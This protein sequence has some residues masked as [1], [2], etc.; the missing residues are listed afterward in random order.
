MI[1]KINVNNTYK[2]MFGVVN[3]AAKNLALKNNPEN[4]ET[5]ETLIKDS[6]INAPN[7][8]ID[9]DWNLFNRFN[10]SS[11]FETSEDT[12][13]NYS[14]GSDDYYRII[15]TKNNVVVHS[16]I[17]GL[18]NACNIAKNEQDHGQEMDNLIEE[19]YKMDGIDKDT[20][21]AA[22]DS[23]GRNLKNLKEI[24]NLVTNL[25]VIPDY[26]IKY[27][28]YN[29]LKRLLGKNDCYIVEN[30]KTDELVKSN[31]ETFKEAYN[32]AEYAQEKTNTINTILNK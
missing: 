2:P 22:I 27:V 5:I 25:K 10:D 3:E 14:L 16:N 30:N 15:N 1:S 8:E 32:A 18:Q 17:Y 13:G 29:F 23:A 4:S 7:Y 20:A 28:H 11:T 6:K 9:V 19:I 24:K 21:K 31:I 26:K 12:L